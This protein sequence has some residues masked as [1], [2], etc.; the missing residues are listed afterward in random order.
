MKKKLTKKDKADAKFKKINQNIESV[1]LIAALLY[2]QECWRLY[3]NCQN[4]KDVCRLMCPTIA[5][6]TLF[7]L[8]QVGIITINVMSKEYIGLFSNAAMLAMR[9]LEP[10]EQK[11]VWN[12]L[13]KKLGD[14]LKSNPKSLTAD[15]VNEAMYEL[16]YISTSLGQSKMPLRQSK[17]LVTAIKTENT[18][19]IAHCIGL[20]IKSDDVLKGLIGDLEKALD[21]RKKQT[22]MPSKTVE[23]QTKP[24][25]NTLKTRRSKNS[26]SA[27][28]TS[29]ARRG[30][31]NGRK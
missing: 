1:I 12:H 10:E 17:A 23:S 15:K 3:E 20:L 9:T 8:A 21:D 22:K 5:Y 7:D 31:S 18:L 16:R 28:A 27:K 11:H 2:L 26:K 4:F 25:T 30:T 19:E 14:K 6:K 13:Q 29:K 24:N